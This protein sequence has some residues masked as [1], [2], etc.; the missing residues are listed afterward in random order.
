MEVKNV[1][2]V[3]IPTANY[4]AMKSFLAETMGLRLGFDHET[5]AE[6][7]TSEGDE[8]QIMAPGDPYY[9]LFTAEARGP[10]PLF[11]VDDVRRARDELIAAGI[12]IVGGLGVD[13]NWE[14]IHFRAPD[15]NLYELANRRLD[16]G[17]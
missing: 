1:R 11:E 6:F 10:V 17:C 16:S 9:G 12:E 7:E 14:W 15:G 3:G 4:Q 5:T 2:W 8:I 13:S